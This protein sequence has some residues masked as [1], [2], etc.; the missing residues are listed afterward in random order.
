MAQSFALGFA[1]YAIPPPSTICTRQPKKIVKRFLGPAYLA[2][3]QI[4]CN[5]C[6][7]RRSF[8][9][10]SDF[11]NLRLDGISRFHGRSETNA[12]EL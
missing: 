12:K 11:P 10:R 6:H 9:S 4:L 8:R 2:S 1:T 7:F 3:I 5:K